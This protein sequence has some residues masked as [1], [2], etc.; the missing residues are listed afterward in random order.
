VTQERFLVDQTFTSSNLLIS[1]LRR[2]DA[3]R[4]VA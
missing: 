2:I 4:A 1:W 3:L